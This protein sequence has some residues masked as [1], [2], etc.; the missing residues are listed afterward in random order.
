MVDVLKTTAAVTAT[1]LTYAETFLLVPKGKLPEAGLD[2]LRDLRED[3]TWLA[4]KALPSV[5]SPRRA[6]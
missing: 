3:R 4:S 5:R 6:P 1:N 2:Y